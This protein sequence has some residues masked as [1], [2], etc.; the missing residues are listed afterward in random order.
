[1]NGKLLFGPLAMLLVAACREE[2]ALGYDGI[3]GVPWGTPLSEARVHLGQPLA[4][5]SSADSGC[6]YTSATIVGHRVPLMVVDG[7]VVRADV[8]TDST[9]R[10]PGGGRFGA[11]AP[12]LL[13][14]YGE[15]L[16]QRPHK[17]TEGQYLIA[18]SPTDS[19]RRV[20]F[21]IVDGRV[22]RWRIG[23]YPPVEYVEGCS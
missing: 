11:A 2:H 4:V 1:M 22:S 12:S 7:R 23:L 20:V 10:A 9:L 6:T 19:M 15:P 3:A 17:Y 14:A 16:R 8:T 21:E 13:Q 5:E 18:L